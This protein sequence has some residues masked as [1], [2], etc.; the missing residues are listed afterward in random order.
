MLSSA[1]KLS[2]QKS[3]PYMGKVDNLH[4]DSQPDQTETLNVGLPTSIAHK[5]LRYS[6]KI[7]I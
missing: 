7:S 6:I 3:I 1:N 2:V 4:L 5:T